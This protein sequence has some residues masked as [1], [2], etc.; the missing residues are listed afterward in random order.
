MPYTEIGYDDGMLGV[1][2][3]ISNGHPIF[4]SAYLLGK[5]GG[6]LDTDSLYMKDGTGKFYT[7]TY[8]LQS[9]LD[10]HCQRHPELLEVVS[11]AFN[12]AEEMG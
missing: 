8:I 1:D 10:H 3:D 11:K 6:Y 9:K 5:R 4:S 12:L 2:F 7:L